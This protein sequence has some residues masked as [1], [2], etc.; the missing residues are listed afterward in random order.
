MDVKIP[1]NIAI[2]V[3][4]VDNPDTAEYR[5]YLTNSDNTL[6]E[7]ERPSRRRRKAVESYRPR[8][9]LKADEVMIF[10]PKETSVILFAKRIRQQARLYGKEAVLN[11][12]PLCLK[13]E[14]LERYT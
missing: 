4:P 3:D 8:K 14:A 6:S 11:V 12:V 1:S 13:G 7:S 2:P 9:H 5:L 10:D